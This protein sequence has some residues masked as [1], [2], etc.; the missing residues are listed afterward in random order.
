MPLQVYFDTS[1]FDHLQKRIN[2][3]AADIASLRQAVYG[4]EISI[5]LS[6]HVLEELLLAR[7]SSPQTYSALLRMVLS[8]AP[9]RTLVKPCP[10]IVRGDVRSYAAGG[11]AEN[12]RVHGP[13]QNIVAAG[14]AELIESD[15]EDWDDDFV[16]A[17]EQIRGNREKF[18]ERMRVIPEIVANIA[19][20]GPEL[21]SFDAFWSTDADG[22]AGGF[23][24][25]AGVGEK[26]AAR[27]IEGLL[28][29]PSIRMAVGI[30]LS[31]IHGLLLQGHRTKKSDGEDQHHAI[32]AAAAAEILVTAD[33]RLLKIAARV[34]MDNFEAIDLRAF[35]DRLDA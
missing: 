7:R 10:D 14:I 16:A 35:L 30:R 31:Y 13:V 19:F 17:L 4:G 11:G 6:I 15:G 2:C 12:P 33:P 25:E 23:A 3:T 28:E 8:I 29:L 20:H 32:S 18:A 27:G 5:P 26:C 1:A 9:S 21:P 24:D 22:I 34:P